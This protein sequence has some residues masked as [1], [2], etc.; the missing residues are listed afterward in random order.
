[1]NSLAIITFVALVSAPAPKPLLVD[2]IV[3]I[4]EDEI[5]TMRD[6]LKILPP[7][8]DLANIEPVLKEV[9]EQ[10]IDA[11]LLKKEA[12][13]AGE[14]LQVTENDVDRA[15]QEIMNLNHLTEEQLKE[16]LLRQG[17]VWN[18]YRRQLREEI[19]RMRLIQYKVDSRIAISRQAVLAACEAQTGNSQVSSVELAHI[20]IRADEL[21]TSAELETARQK[22]LTAYEKLMAGLPWEEAVALYSDDKGGG[23]GRLGFFSRGQIF[24]EVERVAFQLEKGEFSSPVRTPLGFHIIKV[25]E[26]RVDSTD[27]CHDESFLTNIQNQLYQDEHDRQLQAFIES[28]RRKA[29]IETRPLL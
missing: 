28:L 18:D 2:R 10:R 22:A 16:A 19:E 23:D 15:I 21:T 11:I 20:L 17:L 26:R 25:L 9:L 1:M 6:L 3:A 4:V 24:E 5:V 8:S 14:Q 12:Q 27:R 13:N 7:S 29:F